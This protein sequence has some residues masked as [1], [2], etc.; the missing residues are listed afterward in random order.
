MMVMSE[1]K[2][3]LSEDLEIATLALSKLGAIGYEA[4]GFLPP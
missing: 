4:Y 2:N 3:C 1:E